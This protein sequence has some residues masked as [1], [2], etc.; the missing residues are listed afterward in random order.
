VV[1]RV[2]KI[3]TENELEEDGWLC[4]GHCTCGEFSWS[5]NGYYLLYHRGDCKITVVPE[6]KEGKEI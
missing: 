3:V 4:N 1:V 5:K 2:G 6:D